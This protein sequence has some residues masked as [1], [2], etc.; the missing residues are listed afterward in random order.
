MPRKR[1]PLTS[2]TSMRRVCP[3][4]SVA[5]AA[6]GSAGM[7]STRARSLPRPPGTIPSGVSE[8]AR[9]P[10]TAPIRP[11][12][13]TTTGTSPASA[14]R[15]ARSTPSS[16]PA[17]ALDPEGDAA[18]VQLLLQPRQQLQGA[19]VRRGRVDQQRQRHP[20]D[21]HR[22]RQPI[23]A[24]AIAGMEAERRGSARP[25]PRRSRP[26][27]SDGRR[28]A[29]PASATRRPGPGARRGAAPARSRPGAGAPPTWATRSKKPSG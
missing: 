2:P 15:S 17:R 20:F 22:V 28:G 19:P 1:L 12:P 14:A 29:S 8:P 16:R 27:R 25:P 6:S 4:A 3:A 13:L 26:G 10:P 11:S 24:S 21:S 18:G 9:A 7:P 23:R 5:T